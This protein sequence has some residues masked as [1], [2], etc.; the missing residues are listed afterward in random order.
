[1]PNNVSFLF[2]IAMKANQIKLFN[3]LKDSA[4]VEE[5]ISIYSHLTIELRQ[6]L[7]AMKVFHAK[8]MFHSYL[9]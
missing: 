6:V 7:L 2:K 3:R 9:K 4:K 8:K 1:M 5:A